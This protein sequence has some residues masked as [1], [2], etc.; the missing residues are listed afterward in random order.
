M[1]R[2]SFIAAIPGLAALSRMWGKKEGKFKYL[3]PST[4]AE[5]DD[6]IQAIEEWQPRAA[7]A[8]RE[9][10]V[11]HPEN[12][13]CATAFDESGRTFLVETLVVDGR[14]YRRVG[15]GR[16]QAVLDD[17]VEHMREHAAFFEMERRNRGWCVTANGAIRTFPGYRGPVDFQCR[18]TF[19]ELSRQWDKA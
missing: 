2:R 1:N 11:K 17:D 10:Y 9:Q 19:A 15:N 8:L 14:R 18:P 16:W 13:A 4:D 5:K 12:V 6:A 3:E 7:D